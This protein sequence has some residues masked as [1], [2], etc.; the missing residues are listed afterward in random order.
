MQNKYKTIKMAIE[1]L[2][3]LDD[4]P[5][6]N[7]VKTKHSIDMVR[8]IKDVPE[9]GNL[10]K[11][12]S[13]SWRK[14]PWNEPS[15]TIKENHGGV[16]LHPIKSRAMT[17]REIARIQTFPD[18][19]IFEGSKSNQLVQIGNAVPPLMAKAIGLAINKSYENY[20]NV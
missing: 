17:P 11:N 6:F 9:G 16:N 18:D 14:S 12:Y 4:D 20:V 7:H 13:D 1:D 10:Y 15:C 19:F 3:E 5:G 2:M 8:R